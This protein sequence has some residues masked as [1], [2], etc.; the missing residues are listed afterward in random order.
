MSEKRPPAKR[1]S[2]P[3]PGPKPASGP[4]PAPGSKPSQGPRP[5]QGLKPASGPRNRPS[6][7]QGLR[8]PAPARLAALE[9]LMDVTSADAYAGLALTRRIAASHLSARD[10][11]L[12]T[13]LFYG[14]LENRICL[15]HMLSFYMERPCEERVSQEILRMGMYQL[16]FLDKIPASAVCS[17]AVELARRFK[18]ESMAALINGVLRAAAREPERVVFPQDEREALALRSS[19]PRFLVDRFFDEFEPDFARALLTYRHRES[20]VTVRPNAAR[21]SDE[22][23]ETYLTGQGFAWEKGCVPGA[24]RLSGGFVAQHPGFRAGLYSVMGEGSM[25]AAM[26]VG[27]KPG[28]Q[29]LDAC[30]APGGKTCYLAERM[31]GAGR[32]YAWDLYEHRTALISAAARRLTLD[33]IRPRV[34]DARDFLP[35]DAGRMD[36]VLLDAP[37]S[38]LGDYLSKPDIKYRVSA[39]GIDALR[40]VQREL[41]DTC[42]RYVK[43]GGA[44]VYSTCTLLKEENEDNV[45][46]FLAAHKNFAPADLHGL[47][48]DAFADRARDGMLTLYPHLDGIDGFFLARLTRVG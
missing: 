5:S 3:E 18:R 40:N 19:F 33:N 11:R 39:E 28:M 48:P 30:A 34:R 6:A 20:T 12:M 42:A 22:A 27:A 35:Q 9:A 8:G 41:L 21:L 24:Y 37:C 25:L 36:A 16:R 17:D 45:H 44:L 31:G 10:R 23:F 47:I 26:A 29:I 13:E 15:D 7:R 2:K 14:T 1:T 46:A 4:R 38:G 43:P 32:V